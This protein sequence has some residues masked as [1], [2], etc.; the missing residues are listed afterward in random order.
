M[1]QYSKSRKHVLPLWFSAIS[2]SIMWWTYVK[3]FWRAVTAAMGFSGMKFK[4]TLKVLPCRVLIPSAHPNRTRCERN[5]T[6]GT[7]ASKELAS[8]LKCL[9]NNL[10]TT[11]PVILFTPLEGNLTEIESGTLCGGSSE[12][13]M[14]AHG[15]GQGSTDPAMHSFSGCH[16]AG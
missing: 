5:V 9:Q 13:H 2:T 4:T 7:L 11:L 12:S 16:N 6:Q 14:S 3:A 15:W 1:L 8:P 10:M